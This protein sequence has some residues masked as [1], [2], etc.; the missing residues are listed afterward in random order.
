[1]ARLDDIQGYLLRAYDLPFAQYD[2]LHID[3]AAN[4]REWLRKVI[5]SV[6]SVTAW[7]P[8]KGKPAWTFNVAFSHSGLRALGLSPEALASFPSEFRQGMA[9]RA[10]RLSDTG[11][12]A[13]SEWAFGEDP[14]ALHAMVALH[15]RTEDELKRRRAWHEQLLA[16]AATC[17]FP[18][19]AA[20]LDDETEHFGYRDGFGQPDIEDSGLPAPHGSGTPQADG[21][22]KPL[23]LGEFVLGHKDESGG[24]EPMPHP[25]IL[26]LNGSYMVVRML[27]QNVAAYREFVAQ[28]AAALG[29]DAELFAAKLVG[30]W[31]SG[32]PL[33][34]A[35]HSDNPQLGADAARR[36]DFR[37]KDDP[38]GLLCPR[39]SHIRRVNPRD[40]MD[41]NPSVT[42]SRHRILRRGMAYGRALPKDSRGDEAE[43]GFLFIAVN[44]SISRQFEFIQKMWIN[45]GEF[46]DREDERD[47]VLGNQGPDATFTMPGKPF[48][49]RV[50]GL[51]SFV[52]TR[53]GG[54]FF[55]PSIEALRYLSETETVGQ[56]SV[57]VPDDMTAAQTKCALM[58]ELESLSHT[59]N[60]KY[61]SEADL[62]KK[63]AKVVKRWLFETPDD[64]FRELRA[65]CP[66]LV[67][68]K[69][70]PTIVSK[71]ADVKEVLRNNATFPVLP[72]QN[73]ININPP[74]R[75]LGHFLLADLNLVRHDR[76]KEVFSQAMPKG[77]KCRPGIRQHAE[78][79]VA[80]AAQSDPGK[81][82]VIK[83]V[84]ERLPVRVYGSYF[85]VPTGGP[86]QMPEDHLSVIIRRLFWALFMNVDH[87]PAVQW[88]A[89]SSFA[90]FRE[91][92]EG[93]VKAR[94]PQVLASPQMP[95]DMLGR[96]IWYQGRPE[97]PYRDVFSS[98]ERVV[99]NLC[100]ILIGGVAGFVQGIGFILD[101]LSSRTP[102]VWNEAVAT[103]NSDEVD[104]LWRYA[105]EALRLRPQGPGI[106][107]GTADVVELRGV[108]IPANSV[109]LASHQSA[110]MD[111]DEVP[112]P[113]GFDPNRPDDCYLHFGF[114]RNQCLAIDL[115]PVVITEGVRAILRLKNVRRPAEGKLKMGKPYPESFVLEYD[116]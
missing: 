29:C 14:D 53:G 107:R 6:T 65:K 24:Y 90:T 60:P 10:A 101:I 108:K 31:R 17:V 48:K 63:R 94:K 39:N 97:S 88:D 83:D 20:T 22:W 69:G 50:A 35:G 47:P 45:S 40:A 76:E 67:T 34:L 46:V 103:A 3:D 105:R 82:D 64:L 61:A 4:A 84:A 18:R 70:L 85:G 92:V 16:R 71:T 114:G 95:D 57:S 56:R 78:N 79:L 9:A 30:R 81:I 102:G 42:V 62:F 93:L 110:M 68:G 27:H 98:E 8:P 25:E 44:A 100:G 116:T 37:Y 51:S 89:Q 21:Q 43:R 111:E 15:A 7:D 38:K 66:V 113:H 104:E 33:A 41:G 72:Y 5:D 59:D 26:G 32:A 86:G 19:D 109:V 74:P 99:A 91:Y 77:E 112:N 13:P 106:V 58:S 73:P 96:F 11:P 52:V 1:M 36:N 12:S 23:A 55:L 49:K 28:G 54:Y 115:A 87:D 75:G 80:L 2:F